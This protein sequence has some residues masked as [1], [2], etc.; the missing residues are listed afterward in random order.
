M[1]ERLPFVREL[2][3]IGYAKIFTGEDNIRPIKVLVI[4]TDDIYLLN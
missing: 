4:L 1:R 2:S 3:V